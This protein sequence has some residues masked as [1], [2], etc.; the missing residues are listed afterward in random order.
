MNLFNFF[1]SSKSERRNL[2]Y[3]N[4]Y[5][6]PM[7][8][9]FGSGSHNAALTLSSVYS[10]VNLISDAIAT[11]PINV[12]A[13]TDGTKEV[14]ENHPLSLIFHTSLLSKYTLIKSLIRDVMTKGNGFAYIERTAN[15]TVSGLRYL[16]PEQVIINYQPQLQTLYYQSSYIK[17]KILPENILHFTR[18]TTDGVTGISVLK[19]ATRSVNIANQTE[20]TAESF[21]SSGCN[22]N[23]IIKLSGASTKQQRQEALSAWRTT[24]NGTESNGVAVLP[25]NMEYQSISLSSVDAQ[26]LESRQ[27]SVQDI[28]RFFN[29]SPQLI[30]DTSS[31]T[32]VS[33]EQTNLQFLEFTLYPYIVMFENEVNRKLIS[34]GENISINLDE[35]AILRTNKKD[36]AGYYQILLGSGILSINEARKE[37]GYGS[38]EGG[39]RHNIAYNDTSKSDIS[40]SSDSSDS[41]TDNQT[42]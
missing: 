39:D 27:Y 2:E 14:V 16:Q 12:K 18:Y 21:F 34:A 25:S 42:E 38:V 36:I 26:M 5:T 15:G 33:I 31:S 19:Y 4:E 3:V 9:P 30:G 7:S 20:N 40:N 8:L 35:T 37:M 23:G 41:N 10:A 1:R 28:A 29:I 11:L 32:Y 6:A 13:S 24:F 22:L 17:G